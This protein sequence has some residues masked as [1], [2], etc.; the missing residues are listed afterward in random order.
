MEGAFS[1][2]PS[3]PYCFNFAHCFP[4]SR[5]CTHGQW[6]CEE[7]NQV[8]YEIGGVP[9]VTLLTIRLCCL[10]PGKVVRTSELL[11]SP[12]DQLRPVLR[13]LLLTPL[14][15]LLDF[16]HATPHATLALQAHV[17]MEHAVS[18]LMRFVGL[19]QN[20]AL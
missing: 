10:L 6:D 8:W 7:S 12:L 1:L 5:F 2:Q 20:P 13:S 18:S 17:P 9:C 11:P 15:V 14:L 16:L 4:H 19:S 3:I